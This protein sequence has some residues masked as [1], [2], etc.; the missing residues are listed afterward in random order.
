M[1]LAKGCVVATFAVLT[2]PRV[3]QV[4]MRAL[5]LDVDLFPELTELKVVPS[6]AY[7]PHSVLCFPKMNLLVSSYAPRSMHLLRRI[8]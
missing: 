3:S 6:Y 4:Q 5:Q 7:R 1:C 2:R 8:P